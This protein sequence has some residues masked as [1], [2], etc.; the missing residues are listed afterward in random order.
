MR[1]LVSAMEWGRKNTPSNS[2][3]FAIAHWHTMDWT[4]TVMEQTVINNT[5]GTEFAP[6]KCREIKIMN[7][8]MRSCESF[9]C[10]LASVCYIKSFQ[11]RRFD[12]LFPCFGI[13]SAPQLNRGCTSIKNERQLRN[14]SFTITYTSSPLMG[15]NAFAKPAIYRNRNYECPIIRFRTLAGTYDLLGPVDRSGTVYWHEHFGCHR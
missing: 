6:M 7:E 9:N 14:K 10:V 5:L 11:G 3:F 2:K 4:P 15:N 13:Q 8:M 1:E 12:L